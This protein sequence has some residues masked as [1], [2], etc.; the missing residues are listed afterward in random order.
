MDVLLL[1]VAPIHGPRYPPGLA[2]ECLAPLIPRATHVIAQV[3]EHLPHV[4]AT[5]PLSATDF[6]VLVH[7]D[8]APLERAVQPP[9]ATER[10]IAQHIAG[11]V[12]DGATSQV[13]WHPPAIPTVPKPWPRSPAIP[14]SI[15]RS[16]ST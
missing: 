10:K 16:R 1:Q 14:P 3:N 8:A 4:H 2:L 12:K 6:D 11:L 7:H 15:P 5:Q 9:G 13:G